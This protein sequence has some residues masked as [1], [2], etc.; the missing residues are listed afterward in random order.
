[1]PDKVYVKKEKNNVVYS[2]SLWRDN[3]GVEYIRKDIV[4]ETIKTAEDHAYFA[5]QEKFREK[6]ME[7]LD[8]QLVIL[9]KQ[10]LLHP[11]DDVFWGQRNAYKQMK[12]K[13]NSL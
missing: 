1:M 10:T 11:D 6:L 4:D 13:I 5:G 9:D 7:W 3:G 2:L 12:D 8:E